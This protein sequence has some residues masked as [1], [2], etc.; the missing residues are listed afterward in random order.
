MYNFWNLQF[1]TPKYVLLQFS[2]N[3][4]LLMQLL[5]TNNTTI[6]EASPFDKTWGIGLDAYHPDATNEYRWKG[7]N[8]LGQALTEVRH[9]LS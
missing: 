2:Q 7:L 4:D 8:W 1:L 6:V 3:P 5:S 9:K